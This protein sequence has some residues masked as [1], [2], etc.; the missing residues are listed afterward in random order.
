MKEI[1]A[2]WKKKP[3]WMEWER[4]MIYIPENGQVK[5]AKDVSGVIQKLVPDAVPVEG[6]V[7]DETIYCMIRVKG[8]GKRNKLA[9]AI[10]GKRVSGAAMIVKKTEDAFGVLDWAGMT[11]EE[12]GKW[13]GRIMKV[14]GNLV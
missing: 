14:K 12:A 1:K 10:C 4:M 8:R 9:T 13:V 11:P 3:K 5:M 2:K 6:G 7:L